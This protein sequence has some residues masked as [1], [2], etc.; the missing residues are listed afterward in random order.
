VWGLAENKLNFLNSFKMKMS[1]I[2]GIFQMIF[3]VVL[4]LMN[5]RFDPIV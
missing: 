3:G 1:V 2:L 4:S 5:Y